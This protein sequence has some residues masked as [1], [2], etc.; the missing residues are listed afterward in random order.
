VAL[1]AVDIDSYLNTL[2]QNKSG[3]RPKEAVARDLEAR[4]DRH[5]P[6]L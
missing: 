5:C 1:E 4:R 2:A 3:L 6:Q